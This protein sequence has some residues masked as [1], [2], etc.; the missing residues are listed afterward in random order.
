MDAAGAARQVR[1]R[2]AAG[3]LGCLFVLFALRN[4]ADALGAF[5]RRA[6]TYLA[7][8]LVWCLVVPAATVRLGWG[9]LEEVV[10]R[11]LRRELSYMLGGVACTVASAR[12]ARWSVAGYGVELPNGAAVDGAPWAAPYFLRADEVAVT[13]EDGH[14]LLSLFGAWR[15]RAD[16]S[17]VIGRVCPSFVF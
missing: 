17:F 1:L 4:L 6:S 13:C 11:K 7:A 3:V 2:R 16:R 8:V 10:A 5:L 15:F 14:G 9:R 12:V